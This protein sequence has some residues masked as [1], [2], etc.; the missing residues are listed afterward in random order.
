MYDFGFV[1]MDILYTYAEDS[2]EYVC[3]AT[4]QVGEDITRAFIQCKGA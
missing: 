1:T 3:R 2:G 4:N